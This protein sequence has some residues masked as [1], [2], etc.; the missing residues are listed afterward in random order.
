MCKGHVVGEKTEGRPMKL[1]LRKHS[2]VWQ[3]VRQWGQHVPRPDRALGTM[4]R[5]LLFILK[6]MGSYEGVL[7]K[8]VV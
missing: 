6:A 5:I 2:R 3:G 1:D 4:L 7:R 8:R